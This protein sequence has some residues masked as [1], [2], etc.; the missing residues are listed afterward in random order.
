LEGLGV[1][2]PVD[3]TLMQELGI[4]GKNLTVNAQRKAKTLN[5]MTRDEVFGVFR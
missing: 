2:T 3:E 5:M 4:S 1:V